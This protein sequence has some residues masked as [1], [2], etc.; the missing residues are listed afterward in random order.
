MCYHRVSVASAAP[1]YLRLI[2]YHSLHRHATTGGRRAPRAGMPAL[3]RRDLV[4]RPARG[5]LRGAGTLGICIACGA[6]A[7]GICIACAGR[8]PHTFIC[9]ASHT[10][11]VYGVC[12]RYN[13]RHTGAARRAYRDGSVQGAKPV[14]ADSR[15][16]GGRLP[17][18]RILLATYFLTY[19]LSY[20]LS[21]LL[22]LTTYLLT[23]LLTT[24]RRSL[25]TNPLPRSLKRTTRT[26][27]S[28]L[29]MY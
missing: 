19:L 7:L 28:W 26:C 12:T 11:S 27:L 8:A 9:M 16:A 15:A 5:L 14:R 20:L 10:M 22:L 18:V 13:P 29:A 2:P 24:I 21:F 3:S 1:R 6:G 25:T 17:G 23:P 4:V